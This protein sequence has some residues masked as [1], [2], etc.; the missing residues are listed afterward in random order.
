MRIILEALKIDKMP[1]AQRVH[2]WFSFLFAISASIYLTAPSGGQLDLFK[3]QLSAFLQR[4]A[5]LPFPPPV[6][7]S[8]LFRQVGLVVL[9]MAFILIYAVHWLFASSEVTGQVTVSE[10]PLEIPSLP[11]SRGKSA[12]GVAIRAFPSFLLLGIAMIIPYIISIP[13]L[14]IPFYV[15]ASMLSMT[16]FILIF[17]EKKL[18]GAMEA[19]YRMTRGMKFFIFVSFLFLGSITNMAADLLRMVFRSSLWAASLVRAFFF[20]LKTLAFGRL[21]A[22]FYRSLSAREAAAKNSPG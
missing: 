14:G 10:D 8:V 12:T 6:W 13:S 17:E 9:S 1:R 22:I 4:Q 3:T 7:F 19:S 16:I 15:L 5:G 21:A 18:A 11:L 20:A 2:L